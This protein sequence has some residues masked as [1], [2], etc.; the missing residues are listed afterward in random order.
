MVGDRMMV[1][2]L[3]AGEATRRVILPRGGW[4]DFWTGKAVLRGPTIEKPGSYERIPVFVKAGSVIPM[5]G[6]ANYAADSKTRDLTVRIFGDGSLPIVIGGG[7][8]TELHLSWKN[9]RGRIEQQTPDRPYAAT[10]WIPA[11]EGS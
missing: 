4:H 2:P 6:V 11:T 7:R 3:F 9:G 8:Q 1:A 10:G 5:G